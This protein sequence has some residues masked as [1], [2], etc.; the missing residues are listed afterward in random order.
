M[1]HFTVTSISWAEQ[2]QDCIGI[3]TELTDRVPQQRTEALLKDSLWE[4]GED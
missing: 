4:T 1:K 3:E 2:I